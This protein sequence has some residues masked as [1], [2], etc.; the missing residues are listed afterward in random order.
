[1]I[2]GTIEA[3][4]KHLESRIESLREV[5]PYADGQ[6]YYDDKRKIEQM[7]IEICNLRNADKTGER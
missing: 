5:L 4:I 2:N 6:A 3:Q 7:T 1:M